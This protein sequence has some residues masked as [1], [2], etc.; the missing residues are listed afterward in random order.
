MRSVTL[1]ADG[2]QARLNHPLDLPS[3]SGPDQP[4]SV[5]RFERMRTARPPIASTVESVPAP[6]IL[7][8]LHP[9]RTTTPTRETFAL[10]CRASAN[11]PS[12]SSCS[13]GEHIT[14]RLRHSRPPVASFPSIY[15]AIF[16]S[17]SQYQAT[18]I[19]LRSCCRALRKVLIARMS[20]LS[21]A[22][23][24]NVSSS[25]ASIA[26]FASETRISAASSG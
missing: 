25:T 1:G 22:T 9:L 7:R 23:Q 20:L 26:A 11:T 4:Q 24:T 10:L 16:T 6:A 15:Y 8:L 5:H 13:V 17:L 19:F 2:L 3:L 12:I 18:Y 14:D 21:H